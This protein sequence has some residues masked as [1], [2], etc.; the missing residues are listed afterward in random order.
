MAAYSAGSAFSTASFTFPDILLLKIFSFRRRLFSLASQMWQ[1]WQEM[2]LMHPAVWKKAHGLQ[3]PDLCPADP[4]LGSSA[5]PGAGPGGGAGGAGGGTAVAIPAAKAESPVDIRGGSVG[6]AG[7]T[8]TR[9]GP[10][11]PAGA[12]GTKLL[13]SLGSLG[14]SG[15]PIASARETIE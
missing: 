13:S 9:V 12:P 6:G 8:G 10:S 14:A 3:C 7:G 5:D 15:S 11:G 2:P 4:T 1:N